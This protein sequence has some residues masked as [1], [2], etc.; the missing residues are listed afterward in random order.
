M[1]RVETPT[2]EESTGPS[3]PGPPRE[4]GLPAGEEWADAGSAGSVAIDSDSS[5]AAAVGLT[6][7][8][9][10]REEVAAAYGAASLSSTSLHSLGSISL[11]RGT[12][13]LV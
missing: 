4:V 5:A 9:S 13:D 1:L 2:R 7:V 8:L 6:I 3:T 11:V 10:G 12:F